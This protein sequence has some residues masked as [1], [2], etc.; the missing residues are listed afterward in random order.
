[1]AISKRPGTV[2]LSRYKQSLRINNNQLTISNGNTVDLRQKLIAFRAV[3]NNSS[4]MISPGATIKLIFADTLMNYWNIY[5][6]NSGV[7]T[8]P[9]DGAGLYQ[10][11]ISF[12]YGSYTSIQ[13]QTW[14]IRAGV[15]QLKENLQKFNTY[16]FIYYLNPNDQLY[17][18]L[19]NTGGLLVVP[20]SSF[21]G[22]RI[23]Q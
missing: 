18:K 3:N 11:N 5:N 19:V 8:C 22:F 23:N 10:F 2:N 9:S 16:S 6:S 12:D 21:M 1:M 13:L 7:F 20:N 17:I 15:D 4:V 14:T